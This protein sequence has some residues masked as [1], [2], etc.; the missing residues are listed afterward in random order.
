MRRTKL[1]ELKSFVSCYVDPDDDNQ[2]NKPGSQEVT[3]STGQQQQPDSP[4]SSFGH[5]SEDDGRGDNTDAQ[6]DTEK[7]VY[8]QWKR[9]GFFDPLRFVF[10]LSAFSTFDSSSNYQHFQR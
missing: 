10:Q 8:K 3:V 6:R 4:D 2:S 7:F 5:E 9:F 1:K